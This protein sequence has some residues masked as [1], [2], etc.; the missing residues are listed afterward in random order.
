[1]WERGWGG[2]VE[3]WDR[4]VKVCYH[5]LEPILSRCVIFETSE[6]SFHGVEAVTCPAGMT[7]KSFAGYYYTAEAPAGWDGAV[8][9]TLFRARPDERVKGLVL[10]PL[11]RLQKTWIARLR[12]FK[13]SFK[14]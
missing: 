9:S 3:L 14:K 13:R 1:V 2:N 12:N 8:H 11:E 4:D 7:R 5:S 10:M 6:I